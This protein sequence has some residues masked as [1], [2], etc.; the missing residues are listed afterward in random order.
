MSSG[1][2]MYGKCL[3][4][5]LAIVVII[6]TNKLVMYNSFLLNT[7]TDV[8]GAITIDEDNTSTE[9]KPTTILILALSTVAIILLITY[10]KIRQIKPAPNYQPHY[11][12]QAFE[13][14]WN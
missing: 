1:N 14:R 3:V 7:Q 4:A 9:V 2:D 6:L 8:T 5:I 13:K 10:T 11:L 12:P